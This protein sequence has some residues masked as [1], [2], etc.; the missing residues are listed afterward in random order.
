MVDIDG[1][2]LD[3]NETISAK[4]RKALMRACD[5]GIQ[6]SLSTGQVMQACLSI[7]NQLSLSGYHIFFDDALAANPEKGEEVYVEPINK[8]LVGQMA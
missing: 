2:L 7:I 1:T 6:V 3:K 5:S 4:D 8:E